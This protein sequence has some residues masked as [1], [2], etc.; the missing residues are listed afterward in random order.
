MN[1]N[2]RETMQIIVI[3][4]GKLFITLL[5]SSEFKESP[6]EIYIDVEIYFA[7]NKTAYIKNK[8]PLTIK[9]LIES[10]Q[11]KIYSYNSMKSQKPTIFY[12][13]H[14]NTYQ[15]TR[16]KESIGNFYNQS[17]V[18]VNPQVNCPLVYF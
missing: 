6:F 11:N 14:I 18:R 17:I 12:C 16:R 9:L 7:L 13:R 10:L 2:T 15:N 8:I 4:A 3:S 5:N 1:P